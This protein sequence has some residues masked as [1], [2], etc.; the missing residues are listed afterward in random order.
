MNPKQTVPLAVT[1]APAIAAAP[2]VIIGGV[3]GLGIVWLIKSALDSGKS[4]SAE[5]DPAKTEL[6]STRKPA[7]ITRKEAEKP[8]FRKVTEISTPSVPVPSA[9]PVTVHP[10]SVRPAPTVAATVQ[11]VAKAVQPPPPVVLPPISK[12][13]ISRADMATIFDAGKRS[14]SRLD[15]VAA[16]KRL[17]FGKTAAYNATAPDGRFSAWLVFASDGIIYW[18]EKGQTHEIP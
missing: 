14:L 11:P 1:L 5:I 10:V 6:E 3:I 7:E 17:G 8:A 2:A 13:T 12:K 16:L 15:A 9:S 18:A 4:Q